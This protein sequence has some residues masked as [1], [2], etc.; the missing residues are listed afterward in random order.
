MTIIT[1]TSP[2]GRLDA[3]QRA[4]LAETLTD[5]VLVPEIGQALP[6]ARVG[7][8]LHFR[9]LSP[10]HMAIGGMLLSACDP[11]PDVMTIDVLVMDGHWPVEVRAEAINAV[12]AAMAAACDMAAPSPTWWV[13]FRI[14]EEG[15]WGSR[16]GV[17]SILDLLETGAF[18][19]AKAAQ[20]RAHIDSAQTP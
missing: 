7:F 14:V 19:P 13:A 8:Q 5:A 4:R 10:D 17:L 18:T 9:E 2:E 16:G 12:L 15:S 20:I 6:A 1:V 11:R 3:R